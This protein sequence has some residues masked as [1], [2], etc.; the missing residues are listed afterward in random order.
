M[1][2][3]EQLVHYIRVSIAPLAPQ[4]HRLHV[5]EQLLTLGDEQIEG[6]IVTHRAVPR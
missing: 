2:R 6:G 3:A 4:Q 1:G 5:A